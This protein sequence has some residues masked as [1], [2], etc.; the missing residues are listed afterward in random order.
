MLAVDCLLYAKT[1]IVLFCQG[2]AR[3]RCITCKRRMQINCKRGG[4]LFGFWRGANSTYVQRK[5]RADW[6]LSRHRRDAAWR[7]LSDHQRELCYLASLTRIGWITKNAMNWHKTDRSKLR[8]KHP[9]DCVNLSCFVWGETENLWTV[10]P[11]TRSW[12]QFAELFYLS[13]KLNLV[14]FY[15][16]LKRCLNYVLFGNFSTDNFQQKSV[17]CDKCPRYWVAKTCIM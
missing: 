3:R 14:T 2:Y 17:F 12:K 6:F 16:V 5:Q 1:T 11:I 7:H 8:L 9:A 10:Q 13:R 4:S 15:V